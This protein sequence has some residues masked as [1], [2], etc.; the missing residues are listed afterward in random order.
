MIFGFGDLYF[1]CW[2]LG[3]GSRVLGFGFSVLDLEVQVLGFGLKETPAAEQLVLVSLDAP[4]NLST[5]TAKA[6]NRD[7]QPKIRNPK[8]RNLHS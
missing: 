6:K 7:P 8:P 5:P 4:L 3:F 1:V 2:V